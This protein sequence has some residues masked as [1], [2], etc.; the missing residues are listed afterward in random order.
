VSQNVTQS[1]DC[2][3]NFDTSCVVMSGQHDMRARHQRVIAMKRT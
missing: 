2:V 3:L 1:V